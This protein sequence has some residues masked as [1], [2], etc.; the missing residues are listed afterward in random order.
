MIFV[1]IFLLAIIIAFGVILYRAW[2]I[3]KGN[4]NIIYELNPFFK[5]SFR[6]FEK[7]LLIILKHFIQ[8]LVL[9][10]V[11][12]WFLF[13]MK[14]KKWFIEKL[15]KIHNIFRKKEENGLEKKPDTF[16]TRALLESKYKIK[17]IKK[18]IR[19]DHDLPTE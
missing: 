7:S 6:D 2:Q 15:P 14:T 1:I 10:S 18:K 9:I 4:G 11:K 13:V 19:E 3:R 5:L 16:F 12:Y 8:K 17:R